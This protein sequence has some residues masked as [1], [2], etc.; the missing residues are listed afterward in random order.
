VIRV[1]LL[2]VVALTV[3]LTAALTACSVPPTTQ[4]TPAPP[5][6]PAPPSPPTVSETAASPIPS[7]DSYAPPGFVDLSEVDPTIQT[8]IRYAG[9]HNFVGRP[10]TGYLEPRC[11]LT[12]Q[13]AQALRQVQTNARAQGY[14]L[15]MYDCYRPSRAGQDFADWAATPDDTTKGEFYPDLSKRAL[16]TDGFVGGGQ[17][18]HS[19]GSTVDLTLVPLSGP[20]QRPYVPGEP[21]VPCTAPDRF[22]DSTVDMGTGF[23]CFDSR[24]HTLDPRVTGPAREHRL[25]LR[26]LMTDGGF[27]NYPNEWWHYDFVNSP[28][29]GTYYDFPVAREALR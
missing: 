9:S 1:R 22:P 20:S 6:P 14:S 12:D 28:H 7:V 8:D 27:V 17:T 11:L 10:I 16:F 21:L 18:T 19:S 13:A 4:A 5:A 15:K 25:L 3:A 26:Q 29:A 23:D 2:A 24:S